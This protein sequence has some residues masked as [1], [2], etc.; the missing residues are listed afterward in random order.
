MSHTIEFAIDLKT[1]GFQVVSM[2]HAYRI[3]GVIDVWFNGRTLYDKVKN[4]YAN[5]RKTEDL[6][7]NAIYLV[8]KYDARPPFTQ[9]KKGR[10]TM[11]EFRYVNSVK[12]VGEY[13][14]IKN[15]KEIT[16]KDLY[17][18][19]S[20]HCV[21]IGRSKDPKKRLKSLSTGMAF[22]PALICVIKGKG[23]LEPVLHRCFKS[24]RVRKRGEWFTYSKRIE[25]FVNWVNSGEE[26]NIR[27]D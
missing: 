4:T 3:N 17:I 1:R 6:L 2:G 15:N 25:D 7:S 20:G 18:I 16:D 21:K 24:L 19:K 10:M 27:Q 9:T 23:H 26:A 11:R 12:N 22:K 13:Y 5:Y 14:H 8:T